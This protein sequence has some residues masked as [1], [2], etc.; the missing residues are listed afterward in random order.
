MSDIIYR[1]TQGTVNIKYDPETETVIIEKDYNLM[2]KIPIT[3]V[4]DFIYKSMLGNVPKSPHTARR[5][6]QL[7]LG[8]NSDIDYNKMVEDEMD[9]PSINFNLNGE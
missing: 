4:F 8:F 9:I 5:R 3:L 2:A 1:T 7:R 6:G